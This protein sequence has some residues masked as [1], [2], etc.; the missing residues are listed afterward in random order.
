MILDKNLRCTYNWVNGHNTCNL[1]LLNKI[2]LQ[3]RFQDNIG[4]VN[5]QAR[6][7]RNYAIFY[8]NSMNY[9]IIRPN[10]IVTQFEFKLIMFQ[11]VQAIN[12]T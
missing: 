6:N 11:I 12:I 1:F 5:D 7:I 8:L 4:N 2:L 10:I 3:V 9:G